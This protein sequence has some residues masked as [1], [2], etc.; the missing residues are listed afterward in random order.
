MRREIE[1]TEDEDFRTK[2]QA[3]AWQMI[4]LMTESI[5]AEIKHLGLTPIPISSGGKGI[6]VYILYDK[7]I[8]TE[9]AVKIGLLIK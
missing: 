7:L 5:R 1:E 2:L 4:Y 6:H 9:Q 3:H 8:K